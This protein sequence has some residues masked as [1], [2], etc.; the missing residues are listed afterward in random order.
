MNSSSP[1]T[2]S[3]TSDNVSRRKF[4]NRLLTTSAAVLV[5]ANSSSRA[6]AAGFPGEYPAVRIH[7][8]E[9]MRPNSFLVF[10]YPRRFDP[11]ILV[12]TADGKYYAHGQKCSHLGCSVNFNR[13]QNCLECPCHLGAY[14]MRSGL[15]LH[16][17]PRRP[18]DRIFLEVRGGE[19]W[20]VG[21]TNDCD[22]FV[23]IAS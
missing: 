18:L 14:D 21:R 15:V 12:R 13:E 6:S 8:A 1:P 9:S 3:D 10:N 17:P 22:A 11:A 7:G 2:V 5:V 20:A 16:G 19:L 23:N 4:C